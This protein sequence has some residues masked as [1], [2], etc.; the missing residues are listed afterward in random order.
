MNDDLCEF[1][2]EQ[3]AIRR[4]G[5]PRDAIVAALTQHINRQKVYENR[6]HRSNMALRGV[7][8]RM[9]RDAARKPQMRKTAIKQCMTAHAKRMAKKG[10]PK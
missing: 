3:E 10:K 5:A 2:N 1:L 4:R 8:T 9:K 6:L 7:I